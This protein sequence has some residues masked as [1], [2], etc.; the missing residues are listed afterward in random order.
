MIEFYRSTFLLAFLSFVIIVPAY[1]QIADHSEITL[2][3]KNSRFSQFA[4]EAE[5]QT[6]Y[7]IYFSPSQV[8]SLSV[9]IQASGQ[10]LTVVLDTL[11]S[12]TDY[13]YAIYDNKIF[14]TKGRHLHTE[15]PVGFFDHNVAQKDDYDPAMFDFME[16]DEKSEISAEEK[17]HEIGVR[18]R[19][20]RSGKATVTGYVRNIDTGE[21]VVGAVIFH[22]ASGIA[23]VTDPLG[24]YSVSFPT[25]QGKLKITCVGM[26]ET[27]RSIILYSDGKFDIDLKEYVTPL[28]EVVV[29]SERGANLSSMQMGLEKLDIKSMKQVPLALGEVDVMKVVLTLPGVQSAGEN[30][31]G[32]NVRGGAT[33]QNLIL[34]NDATIYNPSHLF[35]FFSAFNPDVVKS[36]ELYKGGVPAEYGGRLASVLEVASREGNKKKFSGSGGIGPITSRLVLEGP[37]VKDKISFLVGGRSTYSDWLLSVVPDDEIKKSSGSFYDINAHLSAE[38][39]ERNSLFFSGYYSNDKFRLGSDTL[40]QYSSMNGSVKWKHV[41]GKKLYADFATGFNRYEFNVSSDRNPL[42]AFELKYRIDQFNVKANFSYYLNA[43][44]TISFGVS[45]IY[46]DLSPGSLLPFTAASLIVPDVLQRERATESAIYVS[47]QFEISPKLSLYVGLRHSIYHYLGPRDI[48]TYMDGAPRSENTMVDTLRNVSGVISTYQGPEYRFSL[49]YMLPGNASVKLSLQRMRQYI[50]ML[51]NTAVMSPTDIWKLSDSYIKPETGDQVTLGLYKNLKNNTIEASVEGYYKTMENFLDYKGGAVLVMNHNIETDVVST[52]GTAYGLEFMVR[53]VTGKLNGWV[54][55]TYSR[56]LL[57]TESTTGSE[58]INQGKKYP[59]NFDKPHDFTLV[60]NYKFSRR[61]SLSLNYTYS[62]GRPITL[63]L[64]KYEFNGTQR[65]LYSE[66]NQ[67][68]IPDYYRVDL[69]MNI[70]GNHKIRKLAHSSWSLSVYNLFGRKNAYS[71]Y[72]ISE[73][74]EIKSYKMSVFGSP[75]PTLTYN[76][77]F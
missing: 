13:H 47:D 48:V 51:S 25:G 37:I 18:A 54:S 15:L 22:V 19:R 2:D 77:K 16:S 76:F 9:N 63:P 56:S 58:T 17:L 36:V 62:T 50:H 42:D 33:S 41:F 60:S 72:F 10:P 53:K 71:V 46:Y 68:R 27:S 34:F 31:T 64:A 38:L 55:Y 49:R 66:R 28:K 1:S 7:K 5:S 73:N 43:K 61:F 52:T 29:E 26:R 20:I 75:I 35:G 39:N 23:A 8:D 40:Y 11:F 30:S 12:G 14:I 65:L 24:H 4:T 6:S 67:Y 59:S 74:K 70:E 44:H 45:S 69:S 57:Q 3:L 32:I 21:P